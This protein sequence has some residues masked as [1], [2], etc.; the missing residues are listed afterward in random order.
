MTK[1]IKTDYSLVTYEDTPEVRDAVFERVMEYFKKCKCFAGE[2]ICQ[3]DN[4][5][6]EAPN[7]LCDI[8]DDIIKF[9][10]EDLEQ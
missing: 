4:P 9:K 10:E 1:T 7:V 6:I 2:V 5:I 8:A 3:S